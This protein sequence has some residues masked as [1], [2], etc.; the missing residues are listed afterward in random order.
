ML[1]QFW[2]SRIFPLRGAPSGLVHNDQALFRGKILFT[3]EGG[4]P[5]TYFG[6]ILGMTFRTRSPHEIGGM[7]ALCLKIFLIRAAVQ[8]DRHGDYD[9]KKYDLVHSVPDNHT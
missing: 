2:T 5:T 8:N 3:G 7:H 6:S 1:L 9:T 4:L